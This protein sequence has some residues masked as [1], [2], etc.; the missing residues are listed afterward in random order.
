MPFTAFSLGTFFGCLPAVSAYVNAG[1]LGAEIV[2]NGAESSAAG[3]RWPPPTPPEASRGTLPR[4][5]AWWLSALRARAHAPRS[6][7]SAAKGRSLR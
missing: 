4:Q 3:R 1:K 6:A 2:V 5:P 7:A